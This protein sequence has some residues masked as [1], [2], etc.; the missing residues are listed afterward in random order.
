VGFGP[1][2]DIRNADDENFWVFESMAFFEI[3]L[4]PWADVF[5]LEIIRFIHYE[6]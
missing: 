2:S 5:H 6:N 1:K 4:S 3:I